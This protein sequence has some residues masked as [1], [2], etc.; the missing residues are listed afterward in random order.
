V[1]VNYFVRVHGKKRKERIFA[2]IRNMDDEHFDRIVSYTWHGVTGGVNWDC[3]HFV[4]VTD[5]LYKPIERRDKN[6]FCKDTN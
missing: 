3:P 2:A 4:W 6:E 5:I 1:K